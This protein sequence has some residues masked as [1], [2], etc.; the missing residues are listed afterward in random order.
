MLVKSRAFMLFLLSFFSQNNVF[1]VTQIFFTQKAQ[2]AQKFV[3]LAVNGWRTQ[4]VFPWFPWFL[5]DILIQCELRLLRLRVLRAT[6]AGILHPHRHTNS[7]ILKF[8][9]FLSDCF[10]FHTDDI[11]FTQIYFH[12]DLF[13][14]ESTE[15]SLTV[16]ELTCRTTSSTKNIFPWFPWFL[17]D[18]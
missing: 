9:I 18:L 14:T 15:I 6:S 17:C 7:C 13:H 12:T 11:F 2:K 3:H 5:C 16:G 10:L 4:K 1:F 8:F